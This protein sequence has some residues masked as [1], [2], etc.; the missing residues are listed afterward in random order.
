MVIE[1]TP[2]AL[3]GSVNAPFSKSDA[4]R[5]LV[6]AS[7]CKTPTEIT[8]SCESEDI[9]ATVRCLESLGARLGSL[10]ESGMRYR[11]EPIPAQGIAPPILDCGESGTTLRLLLPVV[12]A[13]GINAKFMAHGRL[14]QRPLGELTSALEKNGAHFSA[15]T[16]PFELSGKLKPGEFCLP[17]NVSSQYISGLLFAL[18]LLE[19]IGR[20]RLTTA[21]ESASYVEMTRRT[22][23]TF[24]VRSTKTDGG[25]LVQG[26]QR[27]K[28]TESVAV[29]GDWSN[30][31][32]FLAA[33]ALGGR[34]AVSGLS[35][36]SLQGD[37]AIAQLLQSFGARVNTDGAGVSVSAENLAAL[38]IDVSEVPDLFPILAVV[39]A[40]AHGTTRLYNAARL[41]I[42][43]SDRI[44]AVAA[45]LAALGANANELPDALEITGK[46]RLIGGTVDGAGDHR[47]VMAAA[48]ASILCEN[49]V[50]ILGAEAVNKSY[51]HFFS[52]FN[53]IGGLIN[54]IY[55]G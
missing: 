50:T 15:A 6:A 53:A 25:Y 9:R 34:V 45:M 10:D 36:T 39:A 5:V 20:I 44:H 26:K 12:A 2:R 47:I 52:D 38:D 22:L 31:A 27:F 46:P 43:E 42:K 29:E 40:G 19:G 55:N 30:A 4:H 33:G 3:S 48:M 35:D 51:P 37:R 49:P 32:F 16:L 13:L 41:R 54:V 11:M 7:L 1:I 21:L 8:V 18:P 28:S 23:E 24:G 17:G 14:P